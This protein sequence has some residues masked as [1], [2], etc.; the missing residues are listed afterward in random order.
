MSWLTKF[1]TSSIGKK[2]IMSITGLFLCTFLAVHMSGNL[3]LLTG[4]ACDYN[5]YTY[6]MTHFPLIKVISYVT[7]AGFLFHIIDGILITLQNRSKRPVKYAQVKTTKK[8]SWA[9]K[10][11]ALLGTL[12]LV[13]LIIH[14]KSF[15]FEMKFGAL[16]TINCN[17]EDIKDLY[18]IVAEAFS[19]WWYVAFYLVSLVA[20]SLHLMH[21]FQSAFQT[22]G[23]NHKKYTPIIKFIGMAYAILVP[24]GFATQPIVMFMKSLN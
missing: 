11:M 13:F 23:L 14:L 19:Q 6:F 18:T 22:L 15:W 7:Y 9:S 10:N 21:G 16:P 20:L 3:L 5:E 12:I 4:E 8:T 2:I 1:F 17:G 24:L